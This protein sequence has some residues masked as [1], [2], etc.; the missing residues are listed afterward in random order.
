MRPIIL[1]FSRYYLPGHRAGGPI[2]SV[3]NLVY[4]LK[5][6][7]DFHIICSPFDLG[8][9]KP[10]G[11]IQLNEWLEIDGIK[12]F[13]YSPQKIDLG[14]YEKLFNEVKPDIIYF[15]S[16]F[17]RVFTIFPLYKLRKLKVSLLLA[18]RGEF[19]EGALRQKKWSKFFYL[20]FSKMIGFYQNIFWQVSAEAEKNLLIHQIKPPMNHVFTVSDLAELKTID[21]N[22][23]PAKEPHV[24]KIVLP[25]R[26]AAMKNQLFAIRIVNQL[27]FHVQLDFYGL[28]E[29]PEMWAQCVEEM[30]KSPSHIQISYKGEVKHNEIYDILK[31]YDVL[32]MPSLGENFGHAIIEALAAGLPLVISDKT[33]WH[34]LISSGVGFDLALEKE[35]L[36]IEA[37]TSYHRM[38]ALDFFEVRKKCMKYAEAWHLKGEHLAMNDKMFQSLL[39]RKAN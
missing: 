39:A 32:F 1:V 11:N 28:N 6:K 13:Y 5:H 19:S 27:K 36:F 29:D 15:N 14:F 7:Y 10:Y 23:L 12:T 26:I 25:G 38:S 4:S 17:D 8:S 31:S 3:A 9:N 34:D 20:K 33:P 16:F 35:E 37:L 24:L 21:P 30:K 18:P 2:R 22:T